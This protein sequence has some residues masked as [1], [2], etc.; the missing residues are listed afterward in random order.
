MVSL[1]S[2][3]DQVALGKTVREGRE[4]AATMSQGG[5]QVALGKGFDLVLGQLVCDVSCG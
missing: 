1:W 2:A 3:V 4:L 5:C